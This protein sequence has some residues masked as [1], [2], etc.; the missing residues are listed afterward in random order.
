MY[1]HK[2]GTQHIAEHYM[3]FVQLLPSEAFYAFKWQVRVLRAHR[4]KVDHHTDQWVLTPNSLHLVARWPCVSDATQMRLSHPVELRW[5]PQHV[6][7]P[8][9][10]QLISRAEEEVAQHGPVSVE[11]GAPCVSAFV[12]LQLPPLHVHMATSLSMPSLAP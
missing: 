7:N 11:G 12:L 2:D 9:S 1:L 10:Q 6:A 4:L 3:R 8:F 5:G